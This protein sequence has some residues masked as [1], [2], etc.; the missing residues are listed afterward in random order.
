MSIMDI[1]VVRQRPLPYSPVLLLTLPMSGQGAVLPPSPQSTTDEQPVKA[2]PKKK[3]K[4]QPKAPLVQVQAN[5]TPPEPSPV[6]LTCPSALHQMKPTQHAI[7]HDAA[8]AAMITPPPTKHANE[9]DQEG[10]DLVKCEKEPPRRQ[11][12]VDDDVYEPPP[13]PVRPPPREYTVEELLC[14]DDS[15]DQ[16]ENTPK[17]IVH[18]LLPAHDP[19]ATIDD[20]EDLYFMCR[21]LFDAPTPPIYQ[22]DRVVRHCSSARTRVMTHK[23]K[24]A[25]EYRL[26]YPYADEPLPQHPLPRKRVAQKKQAPQPASLLPLSLPSS[27][28]TPSTSTSTA[29]SSTTAPNLP[30]SGAAP[31]E[32]APTSSSSNK[33]NA[34]KKANSTKKGNSTTSIISTSNSASS[35]SLLAATVA[36]WKYTSDSIRYQHLQ[37]HQKRLM[38]ARSP[39]HAWGVFTMEPIQAHE[40]VI[41]YLGV[42]IRQQVANHREAAYEHSGIGSSYLFRV[43]DDMVVDATVQGN[44][45]RY[46]N[47][48]CTPNCGTRIIKID[49]TKRIVLYAKRD[50]EVGEELSY[51]YKFPLEDEKIPCHCGSK[52]CRKTLN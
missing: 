48:S 17:D 7:V 2:P 44:L 18:T 24:D 13:S 22:Q 29:S 15:D 49:K 45:A 12:A 3:K 52:R 26:P 34:T 40:F 11:N 30:T 6:L 19:F 25:G 23:P 33:R 9:D 35:T 20:A 4:A 10:I 39:I 16:E 46:I 5:V 36:Q 8:A 42:K 1:S 47:H 37:Q 38:F 50:I 21:L 27:T 32:L 41:E 14:P 51:D 28:P 43:D 31:S